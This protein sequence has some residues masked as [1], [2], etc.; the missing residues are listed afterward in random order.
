M[1]DE[2]S[3]NTDRICFLRA[4][5]FLWSAALDCGDSSPLWFWSQFALLGRLFQHRTGRSARRPILTKAASRRRAPKAAG[6]TRC[7][8]LRSIGNDLMPVPIRPEDLC[9]VELD[10]LGIVFRWMHILAAITAVGG[11]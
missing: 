7:P 1:R 5:G 8:R 6:Q 3:S 11:T 10:Y 4:A 9:A 2:A